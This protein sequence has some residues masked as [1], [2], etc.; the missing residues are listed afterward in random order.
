MGKLQLLCFLFNRQLLIKCI[1]ISG[2]AEMLSLQILKIYL[3]Q[4]DCYVLT[5]I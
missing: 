1:K 2:V 5:I 4:I 3:R